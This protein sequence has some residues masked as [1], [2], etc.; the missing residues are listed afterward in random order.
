MEQTNRLQE[1]VTPQHL[2]RAAV[3]YI[4]QSTMKQVMENQ[5]STRRQYALQDKAYSLGWPKESIIVIDEDLGVSGSGRV[6]RSGFQRLMSMIPAGEVG[7]VFGLEISRLARS[8]ADMM[9][10][11]ELCGLFDTLVIDEERIYDISNIDDRMII[12][13][14]STIG[15]VEL[16]IIYNRMVGGKLNAANRGELRFALPVG[17]V[18]EDKKPVLDPDESV[19]CAIKTLFDQ[20]SKKWICLSGCKV[21]WRKPVTFPQTCIRR[22]MGW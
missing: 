7:A 18:Y 20:F 3:I 6:A 14:K 19:R 10:M 1:K 13:F 17:Y 15:E 9:K 5:E 2:K 12:G 16:R 4:R 11:I 22:S 8:S 21:L